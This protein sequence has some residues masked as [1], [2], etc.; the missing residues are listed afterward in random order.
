AL[1]NDNE[2]ANFVQLA[3]EN[4]CN[5]AFYVEHDVIA[6]GVT[7]SEEVVNDEIEMKDISEYVGSE[8]V[9]EEDVVIP[10]M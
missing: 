8:Q 7:S 2:L 6:E 5:I 1:R 10:N 4:G 3:F 9:V